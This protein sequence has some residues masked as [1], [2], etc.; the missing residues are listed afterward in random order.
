MEIEAR[1]GQSLRQGAAPFAPCCTG[2]SPA[3]REYRDIAP[4]VANA[5]CEVGSAEPGWEKWRQSCE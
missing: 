4:G 2:S 3:A 5:V 1:L